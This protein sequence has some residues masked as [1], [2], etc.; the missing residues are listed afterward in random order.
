MTNIE[1]ISCLM[2]EIY[3]LVS[4]TLSYF[5]KL[6]GIL[7]I[8]SKRSLVNINSSSM[9]RCLEVNF[10]V[11]FSNIVRCGVWSGGCTVHDENKN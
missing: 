3:V 2:G 1:N 6:F 9:N 5:V 7:K 10:I 4:Y 11:M 8:S